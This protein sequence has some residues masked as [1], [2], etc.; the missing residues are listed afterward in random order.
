MKLTVK[1]IIEACNGTLLCGKEETEI[2]N[3]CIDSRKIEKGSL[4]VPIKGERTDAHKYIDSTFAAGAIATLTQEHLHMEDSHAWIRVNNTQEA[5][6]KNCVCLSRKIYTSYHWGYW[7]C[8]KNYY[9]RND[10]YRTF[11]LQKCNENKG[12]FK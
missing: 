4:F 5:L 11:F 1:E 7:K 2:S 12:K 8:W 3:V 10:R 6:Q 9:K